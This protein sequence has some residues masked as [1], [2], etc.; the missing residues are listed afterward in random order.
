MFM[1]IYPQ[2]CWLIA[3]DMMGLSSRTATS[4]PRTKEA[5]KP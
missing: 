2:L 4:Q 1:M 5:S 3:L